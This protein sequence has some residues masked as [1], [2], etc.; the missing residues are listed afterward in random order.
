MLQ[1]LEQKLQLQQRLSQQQIQSLQLLQVPTLELEQLIREQLEQNPVLEEVPS[2]ESTEGEEE[3]P[4]EEEEVPEGEKELDSDFDN[5]DWDEYLANGEAMVYPTRYRDNPDE[6]RQQPVIVS[7]PSLIDYLL[8]QLRIAVSSPE[9]IKIGEALIGNIDEDGYLSCSIQQIASD[10]NVP[11]K[12]VEK[13]LRIIQTFEPSGV[14]A[15]DLRECLMIQLR[16][17]GKQDSPAMKIVQSHLEDLKKHRYHKIIESLK[18]KEEELREALKIISRLN[19]KPAADFGP[20]AKQITPDLIVEKAG[21]EYVVTLND[22]SLP[23][24]RINR[25][26]L[27]LLKEGKLSD[28]ERKYLLEKLNS[29]RWLIRAIDQRRSTLLRLMRFIVSQQRDFFERGIS[30]LKPMVLQQA[31]DSLGL[32]PSTISRAA[33]G[34]YVQ[35][36]NGIF[37]LRYFFDSK[38][39]SAS[40]QKVSAKR[41]MERIK[42][43]IEKED[44]QAPLSDQQIVEL[45][46]AEGFNIA[47]RTVAKYREKLGIPSSAHRKKF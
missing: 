42:E 13:V 25:R 23:T 8:Q 36:P 46:K 40:G 28:Q 30:G 29:A 6:E 2:K 18:L 39:D 1:G 47:R 35:T 31:A 17:Q 16:E 5:V 38:V 11:A 9:E 44:S 20:E 32:H 33:N 41:V 4:T 26:Y 3:L 22:K 43:L 27:S 12:E 21:N 10:L 37:E 24:L 14:G 45:L 7:K 34:K 15:R 19:P